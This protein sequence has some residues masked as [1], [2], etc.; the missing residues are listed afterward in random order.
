MVRVSCLFMAASALA[1]A[2]CKPAPEATSATAPA[3]PQAPSLWS[4]ETQ[5]G[6]PAKTV[7]ICADRAVHE[8]FGQSLPEANGQPCQLVGRMPVQKDELFAARCRI[9]PDLFT[10][11]SVAAGDKDSDFTVDTVMETDTREARRFEYRLRFKKLAESCPEGWAVGDSA[12]PGDTRLVNS[13]SGAVRELLMPVQAP[14][15]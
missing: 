7:L 5:S 13:L 2:A 8:S 6:A 1:L 10:V 15:P 3:A 14:A 11:H 12:S 9:G 4:I